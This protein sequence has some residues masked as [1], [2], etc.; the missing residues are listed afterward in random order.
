MTAIVLQFRWKCFVCFDIDLKFWRDDDG[1]DAVQEDSNRRQ[2]NEF[3]NIG[4][5]GNAICYAL[6]SLNIGD[7]DA[8]DCNL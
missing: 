5:S 8:H 2:W 4:I 7:A 1:Y 3:E 6:Q